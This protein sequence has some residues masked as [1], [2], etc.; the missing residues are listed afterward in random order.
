MKLIVTVGFYSGDIYRESS[1]CTIEVANDATLSVALEEAKKH[2]E[3]LVPSP[4][5]QTA[6]EPHLYLMHSETLERLDKDKTV[7]D[8]G[9]SE[10]SILRLMSAVR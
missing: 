7:L 10:G 3:P 2:S 8:Y 6:I 5:Y 9:L 1:R 4:S